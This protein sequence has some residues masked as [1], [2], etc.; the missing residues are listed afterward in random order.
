VNSTQEQPGLEPDTYDEGEHNKE[1]YAHIGLAIY[2]AQCLEHEIVNCLVYLDLIPNRAHTVRSRAEWEA[3]CD[4]FYGEH[5][6]HTLGRMIHDLRGVTSVPIELEDILKSSL[7][8]RNWLAHHFFRERAREFMSRAGRD[9][10]IDEL[11]AAPE[12][13]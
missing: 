3:A 1:V 12:S 9:R 5:F 10:M 13:D 4:N 2:H 8:T 11:G 6:E 7:Q